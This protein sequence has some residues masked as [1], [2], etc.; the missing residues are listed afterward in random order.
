MSQLADL[1]SRLGIACGKA[2]DLAVR[3]GFAGS[4]AGDDALGLLEQLSGF[5]QATPGAVSKLKSSSK[6]FEYSDAE[7]NHTVDI[8]A[9]IV[10]SAGRATA[11][12]AILNHR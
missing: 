8:K 9:D 1:K 4:V 3:Q 6:T 5:P 12:P 7:I 10:H 11:L 2:V